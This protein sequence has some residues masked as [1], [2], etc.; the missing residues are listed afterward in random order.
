MSNPRSQEYQLQGTNEI[1]TPFDRS[2]VFEAGLICYKG[3]Q[4]RWDVVFA[5][6]F[7]PRWDAEPYH[8]YPIPLLS[9]PSYESYHVASVFLSVLQIHPA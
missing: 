3:K 5:L 7:A 4:M 8:P 9:N 6:V 2:G 1:Y